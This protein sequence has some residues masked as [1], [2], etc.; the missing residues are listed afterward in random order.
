[1]VID[2]PEIFDGAERSHK[3]EIVLPLVAFLVFEKPERPAKEK[4]Y[5]LTSPVGYDQSEGI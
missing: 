3:S 1:M 5:L 2:G 4:R